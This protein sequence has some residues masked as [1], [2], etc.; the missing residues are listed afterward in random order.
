MAAFPAM[1]KVR[2]RTS[3]LAPDPDPGSQKKV[4]G[5][6][7]SAGACLSHND[8]HLG[9]WSF[10]FRAYQLHSQE[11]VARAQCNG[12]EPQFRPS[13]T[14]QCPHPACVFPLSNPSFYSFFFS[15]SLPHS[16]SHFCRL[17]LVS[18]ASRRRCSLGAEHWR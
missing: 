13:E 18:L 8:V 2:L 5:R 15:L 1:T 16:T 11:L 6:A 3:V 14:K 9:L 17:T 12:Q 7:P 10:F 4:T